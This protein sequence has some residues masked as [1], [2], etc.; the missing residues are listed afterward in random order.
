MRRIQSSAQLLERQRNPGVGYWSSTNAASTPFAGTPGA[1]TSPGGASSPTLSVRGSVD[2]QRAEVTTPVGTGHSAAGTPKGQDEEEVNLE[3]GIGR[4]EISF[5]KVV[6][7]HAFSVSIVSQERYPSVFG[8]QGDE[9]EP[10]CCAMV[11]LRNA[12]L[13][14]ITILSPI[15]FGY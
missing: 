13:I 3:V 12:L 6:T 11:D 1:V 5:S 10:I 2:A 14:V 9:G 15:L 7:E 4:G 8:A